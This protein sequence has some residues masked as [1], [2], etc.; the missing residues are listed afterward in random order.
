MQATGERADRW[1]KELFSGPGGGFENADLPKVAARG[2]RS[3]S[4]NKFLQ[5][6]RFS[7]EKIRAKSI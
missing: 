2:H 7:W 4:D 6:D 5:Y 3:F 1:Q